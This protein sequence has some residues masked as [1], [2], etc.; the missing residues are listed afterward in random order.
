MDDIAAQQHQITRR[1]LGDDGE[2]GNLEG[3]A[4]HFAAVVVDEGFPGTLD[5]GRAA[6]F[7][8][9]RIRIGSFAL[10]AVPRDD[11]QVSEVDAR[12]HDGHPEVQVVVVVLDRVVTLV[13]LVPTSES[14]DLGRKIIGVV[15]SAKLAANLRRLGDFL[16]RIGELRLQSQHGFRRGEDQ[17]VVG[18]GRYLSRLEVR[19]QALD[20]FSV[21]KLRHHDVAAAFHGA[22]IHV[23]QA[24]PVR[25]SHRTPQVRRASAI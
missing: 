6:L 21:E 13:V 17:L 8:K 15:E 7:A 25:G 14:E 10:Q 22:E 19:A 9:P 12:F 24:V 2:L 18:V 11:A 23:G 5:E 1:S 16:S 20:F 4:C 3:E